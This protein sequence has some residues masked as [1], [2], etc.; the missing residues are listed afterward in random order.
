MPSRTLFAILQLLLVS[1]VFLVLA[2]TGEAASPLILSLSPRVDLA[3]HMEFL[4]DP[5]SKLVLDDVLSPAVSRRFVPL[6]VNLN[7]SYTRDTIW[8]RFSIVRERPFSGDAWLLLNPPYLDFVTVYC[9][10]V[11]D[12]TLSSSYREI[13]LGDHIPVAKRP[14]K[15]PELVTPLPMPPSPGTPIM[16]YMKLAS[17]SV[18]N[19]DGSIHTTNDIVSH[20]TTYMM[21]QG[22]YLGIALVIALINLIYFFRVRDNLFLTFSLYMFSLGFNHAGLTGLIA[23]IW[24]EQA[25]ILSDYCTG[26]GAG[27]STF[28]FSLFAIRLFG[29]KRRPIL[30]YYFILMCILSVMTTISVPL[31]FYGQMARITFIGI[32]V[33]IL[34]MTILSITLVR[35]R[36]PAGMLYLMAFGVS[37][38]GYVAQ[39]MRLLGVFPLNWLSLYGIQL[40]ALIN[41]VLMS[42]ALTERV[43]AAEEMALAT[44]K[45]ARGKAVELAREMTLEL[46]EERE[47]LKDALER[48]VRFVDLVSHE[49]RTPLAIIRTNLDMLRDRYADTSR[50]AESIGIMQHAVTRLVEVVETSFGVSRLTDQAS[51]TQQYERIEAADFLM[52]V[53]DEAR[54]LWC[55][56]ILN[57]PPERGIFTFVLADRSQLKT[58]LLNLIDNAV[59]YGG[60]AVPIDIALENETSEVRLIVADHGPELAESEFEGLRLKFR[61]GSNVTGQEGTGIG[62]Y[63]VDR[64]VSLFGGRLLFAPNRPHGLVAT[65]VLPRHT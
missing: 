60:Q 24:P 49:Y 13:R 28:I 27:V 21:L 5:S 44:A 30:H 34:I 4:V 6:P 35:R 43:R 51:A 53:C 55:G 39:F 25:H 45:H 23:I 61:R 32:L 40:A 17:T 64:I 14:V 12:S 20:N 63:L 48:Q 7:K 41:M 59:K 47:K 19:L 10:A 22:G 46:R 52:E 8:L 2:R 3:G 29:T 37:N 15:T 50:R 58:A 42:L 65:I 18:L 54:A 11:G 31:D 33:M 1:V 36:E 9:Q 16:V 38:I 56:I 62:L 57:L 26:S